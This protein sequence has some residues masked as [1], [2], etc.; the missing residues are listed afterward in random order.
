V[1]IKGCTTVIADFLDVIPQI[2]CIEAHTA[3]IG[4]MVM[5]A[6][7]LLQEFSK[8]F[9]TDPLGLLTAAITRR[10]GDITGIFVTLAVLGFAY[11]NV[12]LAVAVL[13]LCKNLYFDHQ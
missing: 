1:F 10:T 6:L 4:C 8:V 3:L 12:S 7:R 9:Q 5:G 13:A 11:R 2:A